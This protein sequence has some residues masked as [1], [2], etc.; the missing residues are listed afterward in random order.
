MN[1]LLKAVETVLADTVLVGGAS[2][3][4][5]AWF[6]INLVC[7]GALFWAIRMRPRSEPDVAIMLVT[8][9]VVVFVVAY[10]M[11]ALSI[12]IG[13]AF[14]LFAL[15]GIMRYRTVTISLRHMSY[16]FAAI[17]LAVVNALGPQGLSL[18]DLVLMDLMIVAALRIATGWRSERIDARCTIEYDR[19]ELISPER[20]QELQDDVAARTGLTV[21]SIEIRKVSLANGI[22]IL[23]VRYHDNVDRTIDYSVFENLDDS[24]DEISETIAR[25][26]DPTSSS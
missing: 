10:F 25:Q 23:N 21:T 16:L 11:S 22:A 20:R 5:V 8:L 14:G 26:N 3:E 4:L 15:F 9:N 7:L 13:F 17:A 1:G 2:L 6:V 19:L 12:S 18:I 24:P